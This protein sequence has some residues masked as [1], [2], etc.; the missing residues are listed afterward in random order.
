MKKYLKLVNFE[1]NRFAKIYAALLVI[2]IVSQLLGVV[3]KSK[4][5]LKDAKNT[6]LEQSLTITEFVQQNGPMDFS[7]ISNSLWFLGPIALS[8]VALVFYIFLIWYRDWFG[9][10]TFIYR[11]LMLP[12]SRM[13]VYLAKATAI[14]LMVFGLIALQ[15]ILLPLE[16]WLLQSL[17]P[18]EFI[19]VTNIKNVIRGNGLLM[20]VLPDTFMQFLF[21]YGL[22]FTAVFTIF[23]AI[24][25]ERSYR[26]KGAVMGVIFCLAAVAVFLSP[27]L[28]N[29][30]ISDGWWLYPK[31]LLAL[32]TVLGLLVMAGSIWFGRYLINK[33]VTV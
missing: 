4:G 18:D 7:A 6:M 14:F 24:L 13:H 28:L 12:T 26:I 17:V 5:Y 32:E 30:M 2:V 31:E 20:I 15:I 3:V 22:G 16:I 9:K 33:K 8:A 29:E 21:S 25:L 27:L 19:N 23:T 11:L 1:I 10:N